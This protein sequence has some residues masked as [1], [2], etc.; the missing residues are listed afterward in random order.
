MRQLHFD[1]SSWVFFTSLRRLDIDWS[2]WVLVVISYSRVV[3]A[4]LGSAVVHWVSVVE[5]PSEGELVEPVV[6]PVDILVALRPLVILRPQFV[7]INWVKVTCVRLILDGWLV[8]SLLCSESRAEVNVCKER[9]RLD[10]VRTILPYSPVVACAKREDEVASLLRKSRLARN[11]HKL[12]PVDHLV[13]SLS[14][15]VCKEGRLS[16]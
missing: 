1:R 5:E 8:W 13:L 12:V 16:D 6:V 9:M 11:R 3:A 4:R 10:V 2:T 14:G 7:R 15:C